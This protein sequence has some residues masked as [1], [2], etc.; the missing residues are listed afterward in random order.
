MPLQ[1]SPG[2]ADSY[3][4]NCGV[5][6]DLIFVLKCGLISAIGTIWPDCNCLLSGTTVIP[7]CK[8]VSG[9]FKAGLRCCALSWE[10]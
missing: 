2:C 6:P 5:G 9:I 1:Y 3:M 7:G 4:A 10:C 8:L